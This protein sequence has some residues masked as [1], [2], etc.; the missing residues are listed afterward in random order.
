MKKLLL[1]LLLPVVQAFAVNA[2]AIWEEQMVSGFRR[3][4]EN[5][6][7]IWERDYQN[8]LRKGNNWEVCSNSAES[9][10]LEDLI[11]A[12]VRLSKDAHANWVRNK[13][14]VNPTKPIVP[15]CGQHGNYIYCNGKKYSTAKYK[16]LG[17]FG[18][19]T[20][21]PAVMDYNSCVNKATVCSC[22]KSGQGMPGEGLTTVV[23]I[24]TNCEF[25]P[26]P[27]PVPPPM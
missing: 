22:Y 13:K 4:L 2:D 27:M 5:S 26:E 10:F 1:F 9:F 20:P 25:Q 19:V 24:G 21:T 3:V 7:Q 11:P 14:A 6:D 18:A 15:A 16:V 8:C 23:P 17:M 12:V